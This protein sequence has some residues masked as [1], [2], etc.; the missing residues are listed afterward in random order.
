M[1]S[2]KNYFKFILL[3]AVVVSLGAFGL[4]SDAAL[5]VGAGGS[6][7][8]VKYALDPPLNYDV[9]PT[10][11]P[12]D[13]LKLDFTFN[14]VPDGSFFI[15]LELSDGTWLAPAFGDITVTI[16]PWTGNVGAVYE[17]VALNANV[18]PPVYGGSSLLR[19]TWDW[20]A[21]P[22]TYLSKVTVY[23]TSEQFQDESPSIIEAQGTINLIVAILEAE[24]SSFDPQ[25]EDPETIAFVTGRWP[26]EDIE[27]DPTTA[28]IDVAA[29]NPINDKTRV[30]FETGL[31]GPTDNDLLIMDVG[32]NIKLPE[33]ADDLYAQNGDPWVFT[34]PD[35]LELRF[36]SSAPW[37]PEVHGI[38]V[39]QAPPLLD[40]GHMGVGIPASP[41]HTVFYAPG[42][43]YCDS[44]GGAWQW[45]TIAV[46]GVDPLT[47]RTFSVQL[48]FNGTNMGYPVHLVSSWSLNGSVLVAHW[49][50]SNTTVGGGPFKSRIYLHNGDSYDAPVI[51]QLYELPIAQ[52][53]ATPTADPLGGPITVGTIEGG[54]GL[55]VRMEDVLDAA[56]I[57]LPYIEGLGNIQAIV[58]VPAKNVSG[59]YQVFAADG[60]AAF[61]MCPLYSLNNNMNQWLWDLLVQFPNVFPPGGMPPSG[62]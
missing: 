29:V 60:S 22:I 4:A 20:S 52:G 53:D 54:K 16:Q 44:F 14:D 6:A 39:S 15:D 2:V 56:G 48:Y 62:D 34:D 33:C 38:A 26:F 47:E 40:G 36:T 50:Q 57:A 28:L 23:L 45:V 61:G 9:D 3:A 41:T 10:T 43:G 17:G 12:N 25:L 8:P 49:L 42:M 24:G 18:L 31:Q 27:V 59:S 51:V 58:S 37:G 46:S 35:L 30:F 55:L 1:L 21:R 13:G 7:G 32:A 5:S 11:L 19:L